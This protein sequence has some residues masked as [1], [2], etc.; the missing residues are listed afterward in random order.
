MEKYTKYLLELAFICLMI[1]ILSLG[2]GIGESL[3]AISLVGSLAYKAWLNKNQQDDLQALN[4]KYD[5]LA[6]QV[7]SIQMDRALRRTAN[8]PKVEIKPTGTTKRFF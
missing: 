2:A 7:Q 1:R 3:A 5:D 6:T 4:K 8:E